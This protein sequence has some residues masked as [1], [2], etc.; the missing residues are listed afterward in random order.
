MKANI[1]NLKDAVKGSHR[2]EKGFSGEY[3]V[4]DGKLNKLVSCRIYWGTSRCY[5]CLWIHGDKV[6]GSGSGLAGGYG[7]HKESAA[8][9]DAISAAGI[10][11]DERIDGVGE[12]AITEA[13]EAIGK[14]LTRRKIKVF[15]AHA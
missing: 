14:A 2:K 7:Y 12:T 4:I 11:L 3:S 6:C 5:C 10:K 13:L 8:V 9:S 15:K 1:K